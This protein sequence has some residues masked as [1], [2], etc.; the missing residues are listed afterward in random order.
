VKKDWLQDGKACLQIEGVPLDLSR[1]TSAIL[2]AFPYTIEIGSM[3]K[4]GQD[5]VSRRILD[6]VQVERIIQ[7]LLNGGP[8]RLLSL[9]ITS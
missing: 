1:I 9:E 6:P 3:Y 4:K 7:E 5:I 8:R 2:K